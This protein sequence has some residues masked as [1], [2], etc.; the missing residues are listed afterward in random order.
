M[1]SLSDHDRGPADLPAN[2]LWGLDVHDTEG[3][4]IGTIDSIARTIDGPAQAI[5]RTAPRP[6]RF[7]FIDLTHAV[8]EGGAVVVPAVRDFGPA[9]LARTEPPLTVNWTL[10]LR[11]HA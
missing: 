3:R 5:V 4:P 2:E 11:R 10:Q 1:E 8:L 9:A 7:I 6:H